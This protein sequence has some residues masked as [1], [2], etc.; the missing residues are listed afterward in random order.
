MCA[1]LYV[2]F[3][4]C[5]IS[6]DSSAY[7]ICGGP[8]GGS[9]YVPYSFGGGCGGQ[10]LIDGVSY[11]PA[12]LMPAASNINISANQPMSSAMASSTM[13]NA[14]FFSSTPNLF[15][16]FQEWMLRLHISKRAVISAEM[17]PC[18]VSLK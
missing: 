4:T 18:T 2:Y 11:V 3:L 17:W 9:G 10:F 1:K 5:S 16:F 7:M 8:N 14:C 6:S 12:P 13:I 15:F